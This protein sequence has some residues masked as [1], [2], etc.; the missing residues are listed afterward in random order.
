M[1]NGS[2]TEN[3]ECDY[4]KHLIGEEELSDLVPVPSMFSELEDL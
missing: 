2:Y 1:F 4:Y 3:F